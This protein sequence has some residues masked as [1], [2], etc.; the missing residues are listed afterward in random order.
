[1]LCRRSHPN[2]NSWKVSQIHLPHIQIKKLATASSATGAEV[3]LKMK[4]T[5]RGKQIN[6]QR[7]AAVQA[8]K[9]GFWRHLLKGNLW[10]TWETNNLEDEIWS[11]WRVLRT[12]VGLSSWGN[13]N[14]PVLIFPTKSTCV[15][16]GWVACMTPVP[17]LDHLSDKDL[18][19]FQ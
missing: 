3:S 9:M 7:T 8:G 14:L 16:W 11:F 17:H 15:F 1:M 4:R 13:E 18:S 10:F 6:I 5:G 2:E 12:S 19:L